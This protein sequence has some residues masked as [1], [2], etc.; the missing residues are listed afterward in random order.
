MPIYEFLCP[1]CNH[2]FETLVL[3]NDETVRCPKCQCKGV[4]RLLS[5]FA[6]KSEGGKMVSSASSSGC[7]SCAGGNCATCH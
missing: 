1:K 6:H 2:E 4:T 5:G 3:K 7:T